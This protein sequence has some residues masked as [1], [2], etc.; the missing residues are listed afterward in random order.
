[1]TDQEYRLVEQCEQRS[2]TRVGTGAWKM[3]CGAWQSIWATQS[4]RAGCAQ[5]CSAQMFTDGQPDL[6]TL[7][8]QWDWPDKA[9][10]ARR[11]RGRSP[12]NLPNAAVYRAAAREPAFGAITSKRRVGPAVMRMKL[13][14]CPKDLGKA[15][16]VCVESNS[17]NRRCSPQQTRGTHV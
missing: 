8:E 4:R 7:I 16:S 1:M 10:P 17:V 11:R 6:E 2:W 9:G 5:Y 14:R 13:L 3:L 12:R 15:G